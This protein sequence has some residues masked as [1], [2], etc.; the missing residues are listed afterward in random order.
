MLVVLALRATTGVGE[1]Q[2][3]SRI[4]RL[5]SLR[6][7]IWFFDGIEKH[8]EELR[9]FLI[10]IMSLTVAGIGLASFATILRDDF[11]VG[12]SIIAA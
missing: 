5:C 8:R 11:N 9:C 1:V 6:T 7:P 3:D 2:W 12:L 10:L 4:R